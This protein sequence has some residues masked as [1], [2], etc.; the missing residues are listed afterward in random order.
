[1]EIQTLMNCCSCYT[2]HDNA[3]VTLCHAVVVG[4]VS[5]YTHPPCIHKYCDF[6][7]W[8][9]EVSWYL[10]DHLKSHQVLNNFATVALC[11][12]KSWMNVDEPKTAE[13]DL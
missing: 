1:M 4:P 6:R 7:Y 12:M 11:S 10:T 5:T 8:W 3:E 2:T 13:A 9:M